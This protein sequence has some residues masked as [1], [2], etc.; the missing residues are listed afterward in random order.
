[1]KLKNRL[2]AVENYDF[3][4]ALTNTLSAY[5]KHH[6]YTDCFCIWL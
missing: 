6:H 5:E 1:M 2:V 4:A 3:S